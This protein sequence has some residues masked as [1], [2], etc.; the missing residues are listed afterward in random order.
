MWSHSCKGYASLQ[1]TQIVMAHQF[2]G[3]LIFRQYHNFARV[4]TTFGGFCRTRKMVLL[5]N[6]PQWDAPSLVQHNKAGWLVLAHE[7]R[8]APGSWPRRRP[9]PVC[10][11]CPLVVD[12]RTRPSGQIE[13]AARAAR[14]GRQQ[15]AAPSQQP[16]TTTHVPVAS[17]ARLGCAAS[18]L[19]RFQG[20]GL[21]ITTDC[22]PTP[23]L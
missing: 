4:R 1:K 22:L 18:R 19:V 17:A 3:T 21:H 14:Q 16:P 15:R 6:L 11:P 12:G 9:R 2:T 13:P 23:L 7:R 8:H 10:W 5:C 20:T